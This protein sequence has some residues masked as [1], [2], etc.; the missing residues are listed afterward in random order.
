MALSKAPDDEVIDVLM[1]LYDDANMEIKGELV[2][3]EEYPDMEMDAMTIVANAII[4]L[5]ELVTKE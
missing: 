1:R 5:D 4:N 2:S 3:V